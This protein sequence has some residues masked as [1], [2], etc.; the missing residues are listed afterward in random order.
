MIKADDCIG[1]AAKGACDKLS[2][3][4]VVLLENVRFHKGEK[5]NFPEFCEALN[6]EL[7]IIARVEKD[8]RFAVRVVDPSGF[9]TLS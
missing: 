5:K 1:D 9:R 7:I 4:G 8:A 3:G 6:L 2:P